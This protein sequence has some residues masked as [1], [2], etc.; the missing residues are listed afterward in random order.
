LPQSEKQG[1]VLFQLF[2][3]YK[4]FEFTIT[5]FRRKVNLLY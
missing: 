3:L 5:D 1:V 4:E 2:P